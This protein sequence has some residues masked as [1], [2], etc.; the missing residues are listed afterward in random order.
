MLSILK[1]REPTIVRPCLLGLDH[2]PGY[3]KNDV[4]RARVRA[5]WKQHPE[6][7]VYQVIARMGTEHPV[8]IV[9][10]WMY[11]REIR[12]AAAK[13][14]S[15]QKRV[16]WRVDRWTATRIRICEI[17]RRHP[18]FIGKQVIEELG[19]EPS[20]RLQWVWQVMREYRQG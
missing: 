19:P 3:L 1:V 5:I 16:G 13:R 7:T 15:A 8:G 17:L 2:P 20:V 12:M 9:R 4:V 11:L 10:A 14:S 6:C 18:E